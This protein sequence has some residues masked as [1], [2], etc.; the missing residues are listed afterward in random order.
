[1]H[2]TATPRNLYLT[3]LFFTWNTGSNTIN[4]FKSNTNKTT[5]L[6][7]NLTLTFKQNK[8]PVQIQNKK[9]KHQF[10]KSSAIP[11]VKVSPQKILVKRKRS[12]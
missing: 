2:N 6:L 1:M 7:L 10:E 5:T 3:S 12:R 9:K 8:P 4:A 11:L